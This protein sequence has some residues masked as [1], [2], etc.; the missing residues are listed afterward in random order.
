MKLTRIEIKNFRSL[1]GDEPGEDVSFAVAEGMNTLIGPNNCGK[2]NVLRA[3]SLALDPDTAFVRERDMPAQRMFA[4]PWI[5]LD[6]SFERPTPVER[7]L[8]RYLGDYERSAKATGAVWAD[9][10]IARLAVSFPGND[11]SGGRRSEQFMVRGAGARRGDTEKLD[12]A[13]RQFRKCYRFVSV[14]SGE[15]LE[16][17]LAGKFREILRTVLREH[18][19]GE[20]A[21][22]ERRRAGYVE[23]LQT[24]LLKPLQGV[25]AGIVGEL[26]PEVTGVSLVP[27]VPEIE[28]TLQDVAV[29]LQDAAD[30]AL[31]GKG[32]G[33]R[34]GVLVGMLRYL[35]EH[36]RRSMVFAV[37]EPEAFLHPK[38]Q[39]DL[40]D[41]LEKLAQRSDVT[42]FVSTHSPFIVSRDPKAQVIAVAKTPAG[43]TTIAG[44]A[45]GD[46]PKASLLG[47]LFRD[48]ALPDLLERSAA[49]PGAT[50]AIVVTEGLGDIDSLRLA[51]SRAGRDD[52]VEGIYLVP[53]GT[54]TKAVVQALLMK[55]QTA[56]PVMVLVDNDQPGRDARRMLTERFGFQNK[57]EVTHYGELFAEGGQ[58]M[59]AEDLWPSE[60]L[61]G[62]VAARGEDK[63]L[64]GKTRRPDGGWHFDID[65]AAKPA[66]G[67]Y[68]ADHVTAADTARW[69]ELLV[70]IRRR[71]G[72][73]TEDA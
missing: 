26:F 7:T 49:I 41:D 56:R 30:T 60:L 61:E 27:Q 46:E 8:L 24:D 35:A 22:A 62:F 6:L 1:Y 39:E 2:S 28:Q 29:N 37:E 38:A 64:K 57:K 23:Q 70:M 3:L 13:L 42:L 31:G 51:A 44:C 32:T 11:R 20:F 69:V 4:V 12:K 47:D 25:I 58:N 34:G 45:R 33:V 36:G 59:E 73:G 63:V 15:S 67:A 18:L 17:L 68:L 48:A 43:R 16:S 21:Q 55:G 71:L 50:K 40:R 53:G 10:R 9:Q 66:M 19:Q 72:L 52:L 65:Q 5:T 14:A 54:A